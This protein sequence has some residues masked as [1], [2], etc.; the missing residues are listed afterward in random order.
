MTEY[1][2]ITLD[3]MS[4]VNFAMQQNH[5]NQLKKYTVGLKR[6]DV[7]AEQSLIF[8]TG[9]DPHDWKRGD[10]WVLSARERI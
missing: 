1:L 10:N 2:K 5:I 9:I 8:K 4:M 7:A 6:K 3:C